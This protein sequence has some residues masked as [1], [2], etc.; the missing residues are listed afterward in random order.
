MISHC[1]HS[2]SWFRVLPAAVRVNVVPR[3]HSCQFVC[4]RGSPLGR[5]QVNRGRHGN[6]RYGLLTSAFIKCR[7]EKRM[8]TV[9]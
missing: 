3:E 8:L 7:G 6:C 1:D 2:M 4:I 5:D 9:W